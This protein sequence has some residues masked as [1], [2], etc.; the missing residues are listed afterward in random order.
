LKAINSLNTKQNNLVYELVLTIPDN[1]LKKLNNYCDPKYIVNKG[2]VSPRDVPALYRDCDI[3][4]SPSL[5]ECFSALY[6]E[7]IFMKK[8][9]IVSDFSFSREICKNAALYFD[10]LSHHDLEAQVLK[11]ERDA[12]LRDKLSY[13]CTQILK[14]FPSSHDRARNYLK[15]LDEN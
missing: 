3:V 2:Y 6:A 8:P 13:N 5:L 10:A 15:I 9:L 12:S 1:D 14:E 4:V 11:I 7:A